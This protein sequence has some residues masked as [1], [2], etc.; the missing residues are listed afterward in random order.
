MTD[1]PT[2]GQP[3]PVKRTVAVLDSVMS[4]REVGE[5]DPVLFLH[6]NPM[7]SYLWRNIMPWVQDLGRCIAPDL[8]GMGDSGRLDADP[9]RYVTHRRYLDAFCAELAID[10]RVV[11]VGHDWG[12]AL[13]FDWA[14]R[15][16]DAVRGIAY[17]ETL[18]H[19]SVG[20]EPPERADLIRF[21]RSDEGE[22]TVLHSD[23]ILDVFLKA[24]VLT[25]MPA[26]VEQEYRRPWVSLGESR[27]PTLTWV[28]EVPLLG[29]PSDVYEAIGNYASWLASSPVPKLLIVTTEGQLTGVNLEF[30][31]N[32]PNQ[33]EV[34]VEAKHFFQEDAPDAVGGALRDWLLSLQ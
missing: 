23:F 2:A 1:G 24:S 25:P 10:D 8:I 12:G 5:G 26:E 4:Y 34:R 31:R 6:G 18:V 29:Q 13:G 15:H 21:C 19:P 28:Q 3:E 7:S 20:D 32:W 33:T 16:P 17:G 11:I 27:R 14:S 22:K 9:Y 30:C